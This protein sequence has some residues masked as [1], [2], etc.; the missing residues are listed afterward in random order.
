[1]TAGPFPMIVHQLIIKM[2]IVIVVR[3]VLKKKQLKCPLKMASLLESKCTVVFC[4][5]N[6][7]VKLFYHFALL[8]HPY[9][10]TANI[11]TTIN[12]PWTAD[13][14]TLFTHLLYCCLFA[15]QRQLPN[16]FTWPLQKQTEDVQC[17]RTSISSPKLCTGTTAPS[18]MGQVQIQDTDKDGEEP[19]RHSTR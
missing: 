15:R 17:P 10:S 18:H 5:P 9:T 16:G 8:Q 2:L 14:T 7:I 4:T 1:M 6:H 3:L 12:T 13:K 11:L 19:L